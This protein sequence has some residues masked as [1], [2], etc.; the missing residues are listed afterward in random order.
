[1][2]GDLLPVLISVGRAAA[3]AMVTSRLC[4]MDKVLLKSG[5]ARGAIHD[6]KHRLSFLGFVVTSTCF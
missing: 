5:S 6:H 1:M 2:T 3:L 4:R